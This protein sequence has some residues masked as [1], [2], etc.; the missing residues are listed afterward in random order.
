LDRER[1]MDRVYDSE[2]DDLE[3]WL[4]SDWE[5][6][7]TLDSSSPEYFFVLDRSVSCVWLIKKN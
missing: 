4:N 5:S 7:D 6:H 2:S 1:E 3:E